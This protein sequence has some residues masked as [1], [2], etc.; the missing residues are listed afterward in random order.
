MFSLFSFRGSGNARLARRPGWA[1]LAFGVAAVTLSLLRKALDARLEFLNLAARLG[2]SFFLFGECLTRREKRRGFRL[3]VLLRGLHR[4]IHLVL[5]LLFP[6]FLR[7]FF[8]VPLFVYR[9]SVFLLGVETAFG[10]SQNLVIRVQGFDVVRQR[11]SSAEGFVAP[12]VRTRERPLVRVRAL[13]RD[14]KLALE[15]ALAAVGVR[16][17]E[18]RGLAGVMSPH[19][20]AQILRPRERL[21]APGVLAP[22]LLARNRHVGQR[23]AEGAAD[24][25]VNAGEART[26]RPERVRGAGG[27]V[28]IMRE[29]RVGVA[30]GPPRR[31]GQTQAR[32]RS[33]VSGEPARARAVAAVR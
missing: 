29:E 33:H 24:G 5:G 22:G 4:T 18:P 15:E 20:F 13:V 8:L 27:V 17:L 19:V 3:Q 31:E 2:S 12:R 16:A 28:R 30:A 25:G 7:G 11:V 6:R 9:E 10:T 32:A 14:E 1:R 23:H 26:E 21:R